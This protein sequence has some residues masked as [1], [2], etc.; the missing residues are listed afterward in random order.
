MS[1]ILLPHFIVIEKVTSKPYGDLLAERI[2]RPTGMSSTRI[3]SEADIVPHRAARYRPVDGELKNQQWVSP[4]MN[5][6]ADGSLYT[7]IRDLAK[8]DAALTSGTVLKPELQS[9]MWT[10]AKLSN[11]SDNPGKYGFGWVCE[12]LAGH[13]VVRH[14]GAWQGVFVTSICRYVDDKITVVLLANLSADSVRIVFDNRAKDRRN[15]HPRDQ[16]SRRRSQVTHAP[17]NT[18]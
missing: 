15:V 18:E 16:V 5:S 12:D 6:T 2:F 3:I 8:W 1:L 10:V 4:T 7:N 11:G 9:Q 14:G 17:A 13:R